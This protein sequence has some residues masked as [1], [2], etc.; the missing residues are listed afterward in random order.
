MLE[1]N[2]GTS[3][4]R[5]RKVGRSA[6][7]SKDSDIFAEIEVGAEGGRRLVEASP[8]FCSKYTLSPRLPGLYALLCAVLSVVACDHG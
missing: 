1:E 3:L 7:E 6:A 5:V 2:R 4:R 8:L